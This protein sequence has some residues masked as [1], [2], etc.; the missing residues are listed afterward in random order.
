MSRRVTSCLARL[1]AQGAAKAADGNQEHTRWV[2]RLAHTRQALAHAQEAA[3]LCAQE[4]VRWFAQS[5]D[6]GARFAGAMVD[7]LHLRRQD[8]P[9]VRAQLLKKL[10]DL[11]SQIATVTPL[12]RTDILGGDPGCWLESIANLRE[13]GASAK[14]AEVPARR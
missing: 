9:A 7:I 6:V 1:R 5:L 4:D 14:P 11:E 10:Q 13:L 3:R 2:R 8:D 12:E